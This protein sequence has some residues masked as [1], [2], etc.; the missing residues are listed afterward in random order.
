MSVSS[1]IRF[2]QQSAGKSMPDELLLNYFPGLSFFAFGGN[3][4]MA[5]PF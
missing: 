3:N 1:V 5:L 2:P 4:V